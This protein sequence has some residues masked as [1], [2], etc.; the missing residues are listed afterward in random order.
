M[1][2]ELFIKIVELADATIKRLVPEELPWMWG[3]ALLMHA[4]GQMND[5]LE[6]DRYTGYIK[7]YA[8]HHIQKGCRI[9]QSDT[10]APT[11]ATYYLQKRFPDLDYHLTT[12]RGLEYIKSSKKVIHN[13]PNHLGHSLEG[14][15]YPKSIWVDSIMM[16]GVFTSLYAKEQGETWLMDFAKSQPAFFKAYLQDEEDKLFVHSYWTKS[17]RQYPKKLYWGRG[18]GWVIGAIPM[19]MD[20]LP[21][22]KEKEACLNILKEVSQAILPYQRPDGYFETLLN[23][24]GT[25]D[26]ESSATALVASGWLHGVR[27]G[28]LDDSYL[29]P[30]MKALSAVVDDLDYK[31]NLL[32]M[33]HISGPTIAL[34]LIPRLGYKLQYKLQ[35]SRDWSYGL[36]ALFFAG[37]EYKKLLDKG[38]LS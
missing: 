33:G 28:Y 24:P 38:V 29:E 32:S 25:T 10:L 4:L 27:C 23:K 34:Q 37:V 7:R 15:L 16:Y 20:N 14:K 12:N 30:A 3:E 22:G 9:D 26:K 17:K 6:E 2:E 11:L 18:N 13:M 31:D 8:D 1:R 5:L 19:L 35:K 21:D 36:A